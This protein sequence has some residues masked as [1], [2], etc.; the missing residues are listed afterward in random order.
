M[1][2][3]PVSHGKSIVNVREAFD[4]VTM[5]NNAPPPSTLAAQL[6][7]S[8]SASTR[9]SRPD[10]T[11]ELQ[12]LFAAIEQVK[13]APDLLAS[14]QDRVEH[15]HMLIY[16]YA[17]VVLEGLKW[18]EP[19]ANTSQLRTDAM[20]AI[21]FLKIT[22]N[23]TPEVLLFVADKGAFLFRGPEP[24]WIWIFPKILKMLGN[25]L[26]ADL[27]API[28]AFFGELYLTAARS[29]S[30][31]PHIP[32]FLA[33]LRNN[34]DGL[35]ARSMRWFRWLT[36]WKVIQ[37]H[38]AE[39]PSSTNR[40]PRLRLQLPQDSF[41]ES[42]GCDQLRPLQEQCT[43]SINLVSH[44]LRHVSYLL[45]LLSV[46]LV[47]HPLGVIAPPLFQEAIPWLVDAAMRINVTQNRWPDL[48]HSF[49]PRIMHTTIKILDNMKL[50]VNTDML[51]K[52]KTYILLVHLCVVVL[53][54]RQTAPGFDTT[55][56]IDDKLLS[57]AIVKIS[58]A[59]LSLMAVCRLV[60]SQII[61]LIEKPISFEKIATN[62]TDLWVS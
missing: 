22:V 18:G 31:W 40:D 1:D 20:R 57:I 11:A 14:Y 37:S 28:E 6:V 55:L 21:H 39:L 36:E 54:R 29:N 12:R 8:I 33:Y 48:T 49:L 45:S 44:A 50:L 19:F 56:R 42:L 41:F 26:C 61:P 59:C 15:N 43:Y 51:V 4:N 2:M 3:A 58:E 27:V 62:G 60:S 52:E 46:P 47:D 24:L 17:R 30:L 5:D 35:F 32:Q 9:S 16:V 34:L 53:T 7:G 10:E 23:E 38:L 25:E 13:D